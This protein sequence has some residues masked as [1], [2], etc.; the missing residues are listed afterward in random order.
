MHTPHKY[1]RTAD[2]DPHRPARGI[3]HG[4]G[5]SLPFWLLG[6]YVFVRVLGI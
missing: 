6:A 1:T 5:F 4:I 3:M 2:N